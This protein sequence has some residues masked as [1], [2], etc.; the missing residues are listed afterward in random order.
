MPAARAVEPIDRYQFSLPLARVR[1]SAP[2]VATTVPL[3][4]RIWIV[5]VGAA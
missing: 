2:L 1:D 4:F 5:V 3:E